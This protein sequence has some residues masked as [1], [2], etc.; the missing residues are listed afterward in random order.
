MS[1]FPYTTSTE[2]STSETAKRK[3]SPQ[4]KL[5]REIREFRAYFEAHFAQE[6]N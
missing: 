5:L 6:E 2:V 1:I 4:E 3:E